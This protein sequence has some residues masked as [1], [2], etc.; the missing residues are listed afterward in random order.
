LTP[1]LKFIFGNS[2]EDEPANK[3]AKFS[4]FTGS[5]RRLDGKSLTQSVA[6]DSSPTLKKHQSEAHN[7]TKDSKSSNP[8]SRQPSGKLVFGSNA[9]QPQNEASKVCIAVL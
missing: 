2:V 1:Y 4:P 8:A 5:G 3:I 6:P 7:G 9:N